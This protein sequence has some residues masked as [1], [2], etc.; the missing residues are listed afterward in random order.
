V[1]ICFAGFDAQQEFVQAASAANDANAHATIDVI[2]I[3]VFFIVFAVKRLDMLIY[4]F[5]LATKFVL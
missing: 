3:I 5:Y 2:V 4:T 1:L